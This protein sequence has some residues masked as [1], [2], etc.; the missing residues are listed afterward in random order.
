MKK[1]TMRIGRLELR[2]T[3]LHLTGVEPH[4]TAEIVRWFNSPT[5]SDGE[6]CC[7]IAHWLRRGEGLDCENDFD[8]LLSGHDAFEEDVPHRIFWMLARIGQEY[9]ETETAE[10]T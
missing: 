2:T 5:A 8:L 10:R 4:T 9:L 7:E 1:M 6:R 3:N